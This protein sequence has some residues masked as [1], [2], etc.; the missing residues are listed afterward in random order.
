MIDADGH[1]TDTY[2][3]VLGRTT[4]TLYDD[5]SFTQ[6]LYGVS[7]NPV[8][9]YEV[10]IPAGGS[11]K[12]E[13]AQRKAGDPMVV[14]IYVSDASG[15]LTDVY[16]PAVP[17]PNNGGALT[18]PHTSYVYDQAGDEVLQVTAEEQAAFQA[19]LSQGDSP[20]SFTGGTAWSYDQNGDELTRTL[21][22]GEEESFT[23]NIYNQVATHTDFDGNT[24]TYTYLPASDPN[25]GSLEQVIYGG[26]IGVSP[27][28]AVGLGE[29][30]ARTPEQYVEIA[31]GL[32]GD[33]PRLAALRAGLRE[34]ERRSPLCDSRRLAGSLEAAYRG[35]WR[36][37]CG[38]VPSP[39]R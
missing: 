15:N 26:A 39:S 13:I 8:P 1:H 21:P 31:V 28:S 17:D 37:G 30:V 2:T 6:T 25:A 22:D 14:T 3:D 12:V 36:N 16:Q 27:L 4:E 7:G 24:A 33:L 5:G 9:G 18:R 10:T 29:L 32:A 23:Y 34:R 38:T 35:M 11:E 19:W 20:A